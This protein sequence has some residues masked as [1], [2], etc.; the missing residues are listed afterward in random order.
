MCG[1]VGAIV[2]DSSSF[3][4][5]GAYISRMRDSMAHRGPDGVGIWIDPD[6]RI[7][8][9]HR[10]LSIIDLSDAASQPMGN[11]DGSLWISFNGEIYNHA[12]IRAEL[13][14]TGHHRWK[15]DHSDTEVI[16]HAFEEWGIDCLHKF[17]GMFAIA[18]WDAR[19]RELWLVRDRIGIKPLYYSIHHNRC[20]FA[21]EIK[22]L[23]Q[24]P[25][26]KREVDEEALFHYLSFLTT[27]A[28]M[29][30]FSG[31]KKLPAGTWLRIKESGEVLH[32][33][34]Y[35]V[36]DHTN[37]LYEVADD[38]VAAM[39]IEE[40]RTSVKL[41]KIS[42]V[43]VGVFLSGGI[44]S[45][46]NA[47]LFSEGES[48][49][50]KT[51][52]IGYDRDYS[53]YK[54]ELA[55]AR[56]IAHQVGADYHERILT[57]DDLLDFLPLM[58]HLQDEPIADPVCIPIYYLSK[59]ARDNN[60]T[61]CQVG[62]GADELFYGYPGWK[63]ILELERLNDL[64]FPRALKKLALGG[65]KRLGMDQKVYFEWLQRAVNGQPVFWGGAEAFTEN[66]KR[67]ILSVRLR[68]KFSTVSSWEVLEPIWNRFQSKAGGKTHLD[69]MSYLDLNIRLPELLLMRVD[70]MSMGVGL[71]GRV[72]FLDHRF[73]ELSMSIPEETKTR[74]GIL[75]YILKKAV[76]EVIP[77]EIIDR[78]KQGFVVP[79]YD[80]FFDRLGAKT[81]E[82]LSVFCRETDFLDIGAVNRWMDQGK[83][84]QTWYLL[85]LA[86]WHERYIAH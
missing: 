73:V 76:R 63:R 51:F 6:R 24:D 16:I 2:F 67:E 17:R 14:K 10:R 61:V 50:V 26:Q 8:L 41:R 83:G 59:L 29:T 65:M 25:D 39:I 60:V 18:L 68:N 32:H 9:G 82:A 66:Q 85:N 74:G 11:E 21:S 36:W 46:T 52:T 54:N 13:E 4:V 48:S 15:T 62:E 70:K 20:T 56:R 44:D 30:L 38:D 77:Q 57:I 55:Y 79:V 78:E 37:P 69:W 86:L 3:H 45:S 34:Y 31:I 71:E 22:A 12:E 1:V 43:P 19:K 28:P 40:L 58:V 42:D 47:I 64:P 49:P 5:T 75:K 27:P 53:T 72:P 33:R 80:W 35:D 84:S 81:R 7:G 23:L